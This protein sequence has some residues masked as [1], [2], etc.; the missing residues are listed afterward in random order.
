MDE[1]ISLYVSRCPQKKV[2]YGTEQLTKVKEGH[3]S[4]PTTSKDFWPILGHILHIQCLWDNLQVKF[5]G[6]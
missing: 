4:T 5:K 2:N 1:R 6:F 3:T